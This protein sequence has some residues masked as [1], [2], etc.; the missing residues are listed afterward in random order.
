MKSEQRKSNK[1][2]QTKKIKQRK[3]DKENQTK[4]K[5][6]QTVLMK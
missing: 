4:K 5:K 1:E 3:S 6:L 2:N